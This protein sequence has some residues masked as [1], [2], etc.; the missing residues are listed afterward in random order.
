MPQLE[1]IHETYSEELPQDFI[2]ETG[3]EPTSQLMSYLTSPNPKVRLVSGP[4]TAGD[5]TGKHYWWDVRQLRSWS[6]FN[7]DTISAVPGFK[8]ILNVNCNARL[9]PEPK[10]ESQA[11][12]PND[13]FDL[14][15]TINDFYATKI[16]AALRVSQGVSRYGHMRKAKTPRDGPHFF[17]NYIGA[18]PDSL[19]FTS[20]QG[21]IVGLVKSYETW[22]TG[23]RRGDPNEQIEYLRPLAQ[24]QW[25]MREQSCRYGF[26]MT[27][28]ELVCV[29]MGSVS[30]GVG[31]GIPFFGHLELS[32]PIDLSASS[33]SSSSGQAKLTACLA[34][35]YLHMLTS[36]SPLQGQLHWKVQIGAPAD[37]TR[38]K[39]CKDDERDEWIRRQKGPHL[40]EMRP[41]RRVRGWV[42][43]SDDY[44]PKIEGPKAR[45]R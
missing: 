40:I 41:A 9:F 21:R 26:I 34:L 8:E 1:N 12:Y 44:K 11:C 13:L 18:G 5:N 7:M 30:D 15:D 10:L 23:K 35:W 38:Q 36:N 2:F 25:M 27:E 37:R 19:E 24:L 14:Q 39:C 16:N 32:K 33:A 20:S 43:P 3:Y 6:D 22:N 31:G 42:W 4:R 45:R 17:C 29:R 28:I